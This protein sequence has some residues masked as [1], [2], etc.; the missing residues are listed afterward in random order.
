MGLKIGVNLGLFKLDYDLKPTGQEILS[1]LF[2]RLLTLDN[3]LGWLLSNH[4]IYLND[5][6]F[7][8]L[9]KIISWKN[10]TKF[11]ERPGCLWCN[12][13][14]SKRMRWMG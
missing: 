2:M 6:G 13:G 7:S 1:K 5:S 3:K 8:V 10:A 11:M 9:Y 14:K 4:H 12:F